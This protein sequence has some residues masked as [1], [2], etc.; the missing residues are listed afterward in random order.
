MKKVVVL[1]LSLILIVGLSMPTFALAD[2]S[3]ETTTSQAEF[4]SFAY[5]DM[6]NEIAYHIRNGEKRFTVVR[7]V[8]TNESDLYNQIEVS[9]SVERLTKSSSGTVNWTLSGRYYFKS[10]DET[11]SNYGNNGSVDYSG[12]KLS[13]QIWDVYHN[14][15]YKYRNQYEPKSSGSETT[16]TENSKTGIK[17]NGKYRLKNSNTGKWCDDANIYIIVFKDG[18]WRS[19]GNYGK[20]NVN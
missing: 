3:L 18:S 13:N 14:I 4:F 9:V 1:F 17:F 19:H 2:T 10:T 11:V 5:D 20:I 7:E 16:V 12:N 15:T 8:Q 6:T